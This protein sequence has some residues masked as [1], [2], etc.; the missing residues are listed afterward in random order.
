MRPVSARAGDL[1]EQLRVPPHVEGVDGD[2]DGLGGERR[3]EV[4]GLR[5]GS[6]RPR[7]PRRTSGAAAR[8]RAGTPELEGVRRELAER[9]GDPFACADEVL[10]PGRAVRRPRGRGARVRRARRRLSSIAVRL[11]SIA[12]RRARTLRHG[13]EAPR[14]VLDT[15]SPRRVSS[16]A[17]AA[18]PYSCTGSRQVPKP[19]AGRG[20]GRD[21]LREGG[22]LDRR[23]VDREPRVRGGAAAHRSLGLS[24][25]SLSLSK[26]GG[27]HRAPP[28]AVSVPTT[29]AVRSSPSSARRRAPA[30]R[31]L[32]PRRRAARSPTGAAGSRAACRPPT[33]ENAGW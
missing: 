17:E 6:R 16:R 4:E 13:E 27:A 11:S 1:L 23:L 29:P 20:D 21:R 25:R 31:V 5:R 12:S 14:Q 15:R 3:G 19:D 30:A 9:V 24:R 18:T 2:P 26:G 22:V 28:A 32:R 7:G 33:I 10:R 8:W